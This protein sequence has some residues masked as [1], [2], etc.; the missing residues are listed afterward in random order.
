MILYMFYANYRLNDHPIIPN[1]KLNNK[2]IS[3]LSVLTFIWFAFIMVNIIYRYILICCDKDERLWRSDLF[4]SYSLLFMFAM[5]M[6]IFTNNALGSFEY[7]GT[8]VI[9]L[10]GLMNFYVW[11]L[12]YMYSPT[13]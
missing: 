9:F 2:S 3:I 5:I 10:Y 13:K 6:F 11:Y 12:Q 8:T 1:E 7:N 4:M